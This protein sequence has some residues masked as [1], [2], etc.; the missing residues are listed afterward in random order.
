MKSGKFVFVVD[1]D[2]SSRKGIAHLL[3]VAGYKVREFGSADEFLE[4]L[5]PDI[6][7][8]LVLD[9][10]MIGMT[11]E[12]LIEELKQRKIKLPIIIVTA[13]NTMEIRQKAIKIGAEGFFRKP[14]DGTALLDAISWAIK[15]DRNVNNINKTKN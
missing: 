3:R 1:D 14:V 13:D 11:W 10:R 8:C 6:S 2:Y 12:K 9:A 5:D 15:S 7:G 4:K